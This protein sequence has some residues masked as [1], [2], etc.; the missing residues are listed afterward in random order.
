[1]KIEYQMITEARL[2]GDELMPAL[3]VAI[4]EE[5]GINHYHNVWY[6]TWHVLNIL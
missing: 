5:I 3:N 4:L 1:M 2:A 6:D